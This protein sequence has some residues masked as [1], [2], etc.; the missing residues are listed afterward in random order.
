MTAECNQFGFGFH[1]LKRREIRV[2]SRW[3]DQQ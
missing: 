1:P 3:S 2:Q